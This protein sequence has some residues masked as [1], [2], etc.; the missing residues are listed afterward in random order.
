MIY[1]QNKFKFGKSWHS[2]MSEKLDL[3]YLKKESDVT[4]RHSPILD[5]TDKLTTYDI[6]NVTLIRYK[7]IF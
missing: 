3:L 6:Y 4:Q 2:A 5:I 7:N 1:N